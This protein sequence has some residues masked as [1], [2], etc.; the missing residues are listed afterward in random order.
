MVVPDTSPS[1]PFPC[2][3]QCGSETSRS[4]LCLEPYQPSQIV[5]AGWKRYNIL[6]FHLTMS[7]GTIAPALV[8]CLL[9]ILVFV[10]YRDSF[11]GIF[12]AKPATQA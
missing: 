12:S 8:A 11:K 2:A 5:Q 3:H 10:Q 4:Q 1:F 7:P 9:W 6:A